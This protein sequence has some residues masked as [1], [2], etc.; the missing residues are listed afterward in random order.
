MSKSAVP[1]HVEISNPDKVLF[2]VDGITKADLA[3]YY[4]RVAEPML[5]W[6][7]DRPVA[8]ARYPDGLAG[9]GILQKNVPGYFPDWIRRVDVGKSGGSVRQLLCDSPATLT[10]LAGQACIEIHTFLSRLPSLG[11][12]D[13]LIFDLDPPDGSAF[14]Q[15]RQAA[16]DLHALL[17]DELELTAFVKTTGGNGLHVHVPLAASEDFD[18]VREFARH[19]ADVLAARSPGKL[20]TEQRKSS[21]GDRIYLDVMRNGYA[22]LAVA[23]FSVRAREGA[24]VAT[25]L[26]WAEVADSGLHPGLF[27]V[28]TV[29]HRIA[30]QYGGGPW[31][32]MSRYRQKLGRARQRLQRAA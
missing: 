17:S 29:P 13:Q 3:G 26:E 28:S 12:P 21:R 27:T 31:A 22:Q 11:Q 19:V 18:Q 25:P 16:L 4:E 9:D 14:G 5:D 7:R 24:P 32:A 23:P 15:V 30:G 2:P 6:L 1:R 20:T 10:Y 8:M